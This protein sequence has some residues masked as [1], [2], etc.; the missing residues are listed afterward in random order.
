MPSPEVTAVYVGHY[1][2]AFPSK[3]F[4]FRRPV[5]Q[6][7][8]LTAGLYN[9]MIGDKDQTNRWLNWIATGG[10]RE[11][12]DMVAVPDFWHRGPSGGEFGFG[13]PYRFLDDSAYPET[14]RQIAASHTSV[15]GP[16]T[17]TQFASTE[18]RDNALD[19]LDHMGYRFRIR[20]ASFARSARAGSNV[21]LQIQGENLGNS[22]MYYAWPVQIQLVNSQG[23][24]MGQWMVKTDIR[25]WLPGEFVVSA[26]L[27]LPEDLSPGLYTWTF[28]I[29]DP[30]SGKPGIRLANKTVNEDGYTEI[31]QIVISKKE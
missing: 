26:T 15:I 16:N 22:P 13:D 6:M 4:M 3:V 29:L 7:S 17:P 8:L 20:S 30:A 5:A 9:D 18:Q 28:A 27:P 21:A 1:Q 31:G 2:A 11:F 10:D 19:L 12:P 14:L 23:G 25:K 24:S